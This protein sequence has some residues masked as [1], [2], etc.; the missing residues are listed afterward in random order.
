MAKFKKSAAFTLALL[1]CSTALASV[2]CGKGGEKTESSSSSQ[3]VPPAPSVFALENHTWT[4]WETV[5]EATCTKDGLEKLVCLDEGC[6]EVK[7][8]TVKAGHAWGAWT[9]STNNLCNQDA[10]LSRRCSSCNQTEKQTIAKRG[11]AYENGVCKLCDEPFVFPTLETNPTYTDVWDDSVGGGNGGAFSRRQLKTDVYYTLDV[12]VTNELAEIDGVWISVPASELGQYALLTIG[13]ANNVTIERFDASEQY[14]PGD[15]NGYI[16]IP[17]IQHENGETFSNVSCNEKYWSSSWRAT[18]RFST[19][20]PNTSV[21]FIITKIADTEWTPEYIHETVLPKQINNVTA[22]EPADGFTKIAVDYN[23]S[24]YFD[25]WNGVYRRGTKAEP[26][27]VIYMAISSEAPRLLGEKAF[28][29]IQEEGNNLSF[30]VGKDERGNY[31]FQD[32][33]AFLLASESQDGNAYENFVNSQGLYPVTQELYDFL[34]LYMTKNRPYDIP[35]DIWED[36]TSRLQKAWLAPCYY[37]AML[38]PGTEDNP[39]LITELGTFEVLTPKYDI[40]Y[41][42]IK[43]TDDT[44]ADSY[45]LVL[46]CEDA[47]RINVNGKTYTG[48]FRVELEVSANQGVTFYIGAKNGAESLFRLTLSKL[49]QSENDA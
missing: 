7:T 29:G 27:E 47:A 30:S 1:L 41:Y 6:G 37:Y 39:Y 36:E 28:T 2:A 42:T 17:A 22:N 34:Q 44:A 26:G 11:H 48:P 4:D 32:Y 38:T 31:L 9:G 25:E 24:Y 14:I 3:Y 46:T 40:V 12:P 20:T 49:E 15:E 5:T 33:H 23:D 13:G 45:T 8:R 18:W 19:T 21:K 10:Q 16:G 43:Y 35:N